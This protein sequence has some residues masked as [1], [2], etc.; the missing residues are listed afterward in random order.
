MYGPAV[1]F[2]EGEWSRVEP[3]LAALYRG[4]GP[5]EL[6]TNRSRWRDGD[7]YVLA[8]EGIDL[9]A[10]VRGVVTDPQAVAVVDYSDHLTH[11][12]DPGDVPG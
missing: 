8:E 10:I 2:P 1:Y 9:A 6:A 3:A 7:V 4:H 12:V 11:E 5:I